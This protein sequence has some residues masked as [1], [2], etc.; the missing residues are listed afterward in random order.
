MFR[1]NVN[2]DDTRADIHYNVDNNMYYVLGEILAAP[3]TI[4]PAGV[5]KFDLV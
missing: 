4:Q 1:L 3:K 5:L 2:Y